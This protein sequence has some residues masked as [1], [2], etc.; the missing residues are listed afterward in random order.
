MSAAVLDTASSPPTL[1]DLSAEDLDAVRE[2][3]SGVEEL[4]KDLA[5]QM[6]KIAQEVAR[7]RSRMFT[8]TLMRTRRAGWRLV[9]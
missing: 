9:S 5:S 6:G 7:V 3:M 4:K 2:V 8:R 1:T